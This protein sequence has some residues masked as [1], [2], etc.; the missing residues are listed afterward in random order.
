LKLQ[1]VS[2]NSGYINNIFIMSAFC[3]CSSTVKDSGGRYLL[4]K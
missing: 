2:G 1:N 4:Q 3:W